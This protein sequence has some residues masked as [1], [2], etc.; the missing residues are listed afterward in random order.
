MAG[1]VTP[2]KKP[3]GEATNLGSATMEGKVAPSPA[4]VA[5]SPAKPT[6]K[7][8]LFTSPLKSLR[9]PEPLLDESSDRWV[10]AGCV[11]G[12]GPASACM[13]VRDAIQAFQMHGL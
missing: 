2:S 12:R 7:K 4:K 10:K 6:N 3:L 9:D 11:R 13:E 1:V 8:E 5:P